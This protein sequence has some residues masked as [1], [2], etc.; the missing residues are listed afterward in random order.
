MGVVDAISWVGPL[1]SKSEVLRLGAGC[2]VCWWFGVVSWTAR[3]FL[4]GTTRLPQSPWVSAAWFRPWYLL[5]ADQPASVDKI[6]LKLYIEGEAGE[7][8][9]WPHGV[10]LGVEIE[11]GC[12]IYLPVSPISVSGWVGIFFS[13]VLKYHRQGMARAKTKPRGPVHEISKV[14]VLL[15][16]FFFAA[17]CSASE[18]HAH[19]SST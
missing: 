1:A 19:A 4:G 10:L 3:R 12:T 11:S 9:G 6:S 13:K 14:I 5:A 18:L 15:S 7:T 2:R 16:F 8:P 17:S